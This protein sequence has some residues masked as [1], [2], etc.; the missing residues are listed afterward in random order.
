L[1]HFLASGSTC[2]VNIAKRQSVQ[3]VSGYH[4]SSQIGSISED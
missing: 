2:F 1:G 4:I 3:D